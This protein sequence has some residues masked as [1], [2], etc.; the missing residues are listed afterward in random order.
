MIALIVATYREGKP[1][2]ERLAARQAAESPFPTYLAPASENRPACV[3]VVSGMGK[4]RAAR[5]VEFVLLAHRPSAVVNFGLCGAL[6]RDLARGALVRVADTLDGEAVLAG[7]PANPQA[8]SPGFSGAPPR[9]GNLATVDKP[10]FDDRRRSTLA[11]Y[12]DVVDM[13]GYAVAATCRARHVPVHLLKAVSDFADSHGRWDII[14]HIDTISA[15]LAET[16]LRELETLVDSDSAAPASPAPDPRETLGAPAAETTPEDA[17]PLPARLARFVK[18]EHTVFSLPLLFAGA[19]LGAG[20]HWPPMITLALIVIAGT[21]ARTLGMAAN[22][23]LDRHMD[24]LNPRTAKRDLPAGKLSLRAAYAVAAA[25][26]GVYLAACAALGPVCLA[27]SPIP[28]A[29]MALYPLLKRFTSLCHFG[30]GACLALAPLGA[31][32]AA[33]TTGSNAWDVSAPAALLALFTFA[34]MTGFD[35]IYALQDIDSD[36][37]TGVRSLPAALGARGAGALAAGLHVL[38]AAA[39]VGLWLMLGANT[40]SGLAVGVMAAGFV[41]AHW[42]TI[43]PQTRFFP[44]GPIVAAAGALVVLLGD[45]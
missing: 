39:G 21:G 34:W 20:G 40:L 38:A 45:L 30:I 14:K 17:A 12:A 32:V 23:I 22:R 35:I 3:I 2:L 24:S 4:D 19:W 27:L 9:L 42:P 29:A 28:A 33:H 11:E 41:V 1:L 37:L 26:L 7:K 5:A 44:V 31:Y 16:V 15:V 43:S 10:V 13:E 18:L 8:C 6:S 25:G 36:R